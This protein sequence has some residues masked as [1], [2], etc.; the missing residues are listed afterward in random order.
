MAYV[1]ADELEDM[2]EHFG[3]TRRGDWVVSIVNL[4]GFAVSEDLIAVTGRRWPEYKRL[5]V[6]L[7][8]EVCV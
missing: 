2:Q 6:Q 8:T 1:P 4:D 3:V 7:G 5:R